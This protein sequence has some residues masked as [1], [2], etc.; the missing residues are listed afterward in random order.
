V[1]VEIVAEGQSALKD[2][3]AGSATGHLTCGVA[4]VADQLHSVL[5]EDED[6][7]EAVQEEDLV[8][9]GL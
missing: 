4:L 9:Q 8:D 2:G 7:A 6:V 5:P 3:Q 1:E